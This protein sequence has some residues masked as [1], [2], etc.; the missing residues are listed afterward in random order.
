MSGI[1]RDDLHWFSCFNGPLASFL[2]NIKPIWTGF[3]WLFLKMHECNSKFNAAL[4]ALC[5]IDFLYSNSNAK[6][7]AYSNIVRIHELNLFVCILENVLWYSVKQGCRH[8]ESR[9][10]AFCDFVWFVW[11][12]SV[13]LILLSHRRRLC[14]LKLLVLL[15]TSLTT[16]QLCCYKH[17]RTVLEADGSSCHSVLGCHDFPQLYYTCTCKKTKW[18]IFHW[19]CFLHPLKYYCFS[20]STNTSNSRVKDFVLCQQRACKN[21]ISS[22]LKVKTLSRTASSRSRHN[23]ETWSHSFSPALALL[24]QLLLSWDSAAVKPFGLWSCSSLRDCFSDTS[25]PSF[26]T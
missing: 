26:F 23:P 20:Q 24:P 25:R 11:S 16:S 12:K 6:H 14:C 18:I 21:I 15:W 10:G 1:N 17:S 9:P 7:W 22:V 4:N 2:R 8:A 13:I 5:D 19:V 3:T